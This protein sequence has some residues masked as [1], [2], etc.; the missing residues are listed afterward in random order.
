MYEIYEQIDTISIDLPLKKFNFFKYQIRSVLNYNHVNY[1]YERL[2]GVKFQLF[3]ELIETHNYPTASFIKTTSKL[4]Y[5]KT[6]SKRGNFVLNHRLGFS[7]N[8]ISPFSPFVFDG[9][10]LQ[11]LNQNGFSFG[12]GQFFKI[13]TTLFYGAIH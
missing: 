7:T 8:N 13:S 9:F 2:D 4:T 10:N 6:I 1:K 3:F 11:N 12:V 5:Y